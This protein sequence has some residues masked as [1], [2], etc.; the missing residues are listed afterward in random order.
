MSK[1]KAF[2]YLRFSTPEQHKGDSLR[3]QTE[4]AAEYAKAN[5]LDLDDRSFEDMGVSAFRG[6]NA[7][8]GRLAE[9]IEAVEY[10]EVPKGSYLLIESLD[11]L[12]RAKPRKASR[13]LE[14]IC[15]EGIT[16]VTLTDGKVYDE[17]TLDDDHLAFFYVLL[18]AIRANEESEMKSQRL[19][20]AWKAKRLNAST[21]PLTSRCPA[22]LRLN[23]DEGKFEII[24][25]R[26]KIIKEIFHLTLKG[27]GQHKIAE[28]FN[29]RG[30]ETFGRST[31]W[32]RS[33]IK[34]VIENP[35]VIGTYPPHVMQ[36][37]DG[38]RIKIPQEPIANYYPPIVDIE[39][40]ER[41]QSTNTT[42]TPPSKGKRGAIQNVLA[43]LAKCPLCDSTM[44]RV[45]KG[46]AAKPSLV[47]TKA[48]VGAGCKYKGVRLDD[49]EDTLITN[50]S[51]IT[52]S[53]PL[54]DDGLEKKLEETEVQISGIEDAINNIVSSIKRS[55][56]KR[57]SAEL[58]EL[59]EN[60]GELKG[61]ERRLLDI[62]KDTARPI[63]VKKLN[64]LEKC[65]SEEPLNRNLANTLFRQLL[66]C[67]IVDW[68]N[69]Q[70][71][72]DWKHGEETRILF[73]WPE[74]DILH[75]QH[76]KIKN[77]E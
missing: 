17:Q 5:G 21:R 44:T 12:S 43:S 14:R 32:H 28:T 63:L 39:V 72:F 1:P 31:F 64:E 15:E 69:S 26:A 71:M 65:L 10:G 13:L 66:N 56:S 37:I 68:P 73:K 11:R 59:E 23:K 7:E 62:A 19:K 25:N 75:L 9:F 45:N 40:F 46:K 77:C 55:P 35:A 30:E 57:L 3:R 8:T 42:R 60:L 22:W 24:P 50:A 33:Y 52:A 54:G 61:E 16:V 4:A 18:V 20:A 6:S 74:E 76:K 47:C 58:M 41:V 67:V 29:K 49:I 2:S 27:V 48:K 53:A 70:L 36:H 51:F 38:N 34:K